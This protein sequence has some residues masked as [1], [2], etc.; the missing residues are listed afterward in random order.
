MFR[1]KTQYIRSDDS[2]PELFIEGLDYANSELLYIL[3]NEVNLSDYLIT[4]YEHRIDLICSDIY[5]TDKYSWI[6]LYINRIKVSELVRGKVIKY[7]NK[8]RLITI[9]NSL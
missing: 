2:S 9:L 4:R 1:R 6:L 3:D 5:S 8:D 7:I